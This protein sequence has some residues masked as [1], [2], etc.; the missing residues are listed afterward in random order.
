MLSEIQILNRIQDVCAEVLKA[1]RETV[2]GP[3]R[4]KE[5]LG[6]DSLDMMTL[7]MALENEFAGTISDEEAKQLATVQDVL[8]LLKSRQ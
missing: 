1:N 4:F 5:D 8:N 2:I 3:S 6:A 7:L